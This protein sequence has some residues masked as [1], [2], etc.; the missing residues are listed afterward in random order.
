MLENVHDGMQEFKEYNNEHT[1]KC[2]IH[3]AYYAA[4]DDYE[5]HFEET[6]GKGVADCRMI[7]RKP[8]IPAIIVELKY[9]HSADEAINQILDKNYISKFPAYVH[10]VLCI[11][12]NYNKQTKKHECRIVEKNC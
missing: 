7:P 5:L 10:K 3:L 1:S 8:G 11:G 2:V 9:N 12:I 6:A 4:V